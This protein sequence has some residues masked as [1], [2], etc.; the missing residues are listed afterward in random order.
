MQSELCPTESVFVD[1]MADALEKVYEC[2]PERYYVIDTKENK[3]AF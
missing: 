2:R 3:I 1:G